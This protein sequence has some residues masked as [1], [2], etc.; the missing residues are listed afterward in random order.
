[1][2]VLVLVPLFPHLRLHLLLLQLLLLLLIAVLVL[3]L[4]LAAC[5][6]LFRS[7]LRVCRN[8]KATSE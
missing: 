5:S 3:L 7:A 6:M 1:L 2:L 4:L 8:E